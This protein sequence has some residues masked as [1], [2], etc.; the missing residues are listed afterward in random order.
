MGLGIHSPLRHTSSGSELIEDFGVITQDDENEVIRCHLNDVETT[1]SLGDP[2]FGHNLLL[3]ESEE[4]GVGS[5]S[6]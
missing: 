2:G 1:D 6:E 5:F 4:I 3:C